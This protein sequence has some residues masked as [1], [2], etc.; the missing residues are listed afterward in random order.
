M[1]VKVVWVVVAGTGAGAAIRP[2]DLETIETASDMVSIRRYGSWGDR[3]PV[4]CVD[5]SQILTTHTT[6]LGQVMLNMVVVRV[7]WRPSGGGANT[8][9]H[10]YELT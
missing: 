6:N 10:L 9:R 2:I 5:S 4:V 3:E 1:L 7:V 8:R